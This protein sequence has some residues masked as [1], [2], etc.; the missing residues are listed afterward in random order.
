VH[1]FALLTLLRSQLEA[2]RAAVPVKFKTIDSARADSVLLLSLVASAGCPPESGAPQQFAAAFKAGAD[3]MRLKDAVP[4]GRDAI[5]LDAVAAALENLRG[6]APLAKGALVK[7]LF[8]AV[9]ADGTIRVMEAELMR[10]VGAV[11]DCPLPPLLEYVEPA[12]MAA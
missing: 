8:A 12:A 1:E 10:M 5:R 3:E 2:R 6:L 11:L 7:G 9:T 4:V